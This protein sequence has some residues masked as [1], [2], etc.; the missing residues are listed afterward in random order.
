MLPPDWY[1]T[2]RNL[3]Y[4]NSRKPE[5]LDPGDKLAV[6]T[7]LQ[8]R[9]AALAAAQLLA[10]KPRGRHALLVLTDKPWAMS[11]VHAARTSQNSCIC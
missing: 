5:A 1:G 6:L 4:R 8:Q 7:E 11:L 3:I 9:D 2:A 10:D